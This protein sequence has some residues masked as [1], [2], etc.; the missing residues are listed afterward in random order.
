MKGQQLLYDV[1][2][3]W[4]IMLL[5]GIIFYFIYPKYHFISSVVRGNRI[6]GDVEILI[7]GKWEKSDF[8]HADKQG[9]QLL[10]R[11]REHGAE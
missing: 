10:R 2:K 6:T 9:E 4:L 7:G 11:L 8:T 5:A 1:A 3:W